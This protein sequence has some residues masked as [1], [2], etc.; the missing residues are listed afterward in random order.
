MT[1]TQT[2]TQGTIQQTLQQVATE[3]NQPGNAEAASPAREEARR[4][5]QICNACR[6]C[7]GFCS[8]FPAM[9]QHRHFSDGTLDHLANLCHNCRGCYYACQYAEPHEFNVNVPK[10]FNELR[11]QSWQDHAWPGFMA[12]AFAGNGLILSLACA[13]A[14]AFVFIGSAMLND[15]DGFFRAYPDGNFKAIIPHGVMVAVAGP[16]FLFALFAM[17]VGGWSFWQASTPL[18]PRKETPNRA[19]SGA[20]GQIG[21]NFLKALK[22]TLTLKNLSGAGHGCNDD[23]E[24]FSMKRRYLHHATFYGFM[25][26]FAATSTGTI[27]H[28]V[29]GWESPHGYFSLPVMFGTVGGVLLCIGT[30]GLHQMKL[31]TEA[32]LKSPALWGMETGFIA[33]LFFTSLTGLLLLF[34]RETAVM[35]TMLAVHLGFVLTLFL[36]LPY[37]KMVHGVYRF[38]ALLR[39]HQSN[40]ST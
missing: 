13:L 39:F 31:K 17:G 8:V 25:L 23:S 20:E 36:V 38:L 4:I 2:Q 21:T 11:A 16:V 29:F 12:R 3:N 35:G 22:D 19:L 14:M 9:T 6:Y 34:L 28:Y 24:R 1:D 40:S 37:S 32:S 18:S 27:Y 10:T 33:L 15:M 26:C 30:A 5:M 7:E